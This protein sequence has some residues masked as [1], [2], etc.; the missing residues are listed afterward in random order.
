MADIQSKILGKYGVDISQENL[1]KLYKIENADISPQELESKIQDAHKRWNTSINGANEKIAKR[2]QARLDQADKLEAI[3]RDARLLREL[4][5]YYNG[6]PGETSP[7][8]DPEAL[9]FAREY[10]Q[11][12]GTTKKIKKSD[13]EFFFKYYQSQRKN[14]KAILEMLSKELRVTGLGKDAGYGADEDTFEG[15]KKNDNSPLIVSL[16]QEATVLKIRRA[17]EKYEESAASEELCQHYPALK[18]GMYAFLDLD[19]VQTSGQFSYKMSEMGKEVYALRQEKGTEYVPLVDFFN[20]LQSISEYRDVVDNMQEFKLLLKYPNLTPYM[21]A[22]VEMKPNT[23]RAM[24]EVAKRD[25]SFRNETDF[26]LNYYGKLYDNFGIINTGIGNIIKEAEKRAK[27]SA[28]L[29]KIDE[30]LGRTRNGKL[31]L[32]ALIIHWLVYWPVFAVYIVI[33]IAKIIFNN[34]G[35]L[36]IPISALILILENF[37]LPDSSIGIPSLM[38]FTKIF[39]VQEWTEVITEVLGIMPETATEFISYSIYTIL[40]M[41]GIYLV[42]PVFVGLFVD[43]FADGF[44][45]LFDW[46]GYERT[47][48]NIMRNLRRKTENEYREQPREFIKNKL[49]GIAINIVSL[50]VLIICLHLVSIGI[51]KVTE[52]LGFEQNESIDTEDDRDGI[53]GFGRIQKTGEIMEITVES[54]NIRSGPGT[55]NDI[56]TTAKKGDTFVATGNES[57]SLDGST[58]YEIY[59]DDDMTETGWASEKVI[60]SK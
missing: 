17:V 55:D 16:F 9:A 23:L 11:I 51:G 41:L 29:D 24:V 37:I 12:V 35:R 36:V 2:D 18:D 32:L 10:F 59:L 1:L 38:A 31:P 47:L 4:D 57:Q 46:K 54:A 56:I 7:T 27:Q 48:K 49:P 28:V 15:K 20:I 26:Y 14:K 3:L 34:L 6:A 39:S 30:R 25:Y 60:S 33:E 5:S 22:F 43:N 19:G 8:A 45:K 13:V 53:F 50:I 58:W 52:N 44:N 42:V 40:I 21:F